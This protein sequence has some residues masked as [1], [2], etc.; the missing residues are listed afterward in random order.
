MTEKK[1]RFITLTYKPYYWQ[2]SAKEQ[3]RN[4]FRSMESGLFLLSYEYYWIGIELTEGGIIHMHILLEVKRG[5]LNMIR[6]WVKAWKEYG[7]TQIVE[8]VRL[9]ECKDYCIK[10]KLDVFTILYGL[11]DQ[12]DCIT[13]LNYA[14]YKQIVGPVGDEYKSIDQYFP[15]R[16]KEQKDIENNGINVFK[17]SGIP[18]KN[19]I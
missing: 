18:G 19:N 2:W 3:I 7:F 6:L 1:Y 11:K 17:Y 12:D 9:S 4:F 8:P 14:Y 15:E 5:H 13:P 16:K 10:D